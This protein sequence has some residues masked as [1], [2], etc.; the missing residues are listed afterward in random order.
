MRI[1]RGPSVN[2]GVHAAR[3]RAH[4]LEASGDEVVRILE[5]VDV[6]PGTVLQLHV[7][8]LVLAD[9]SLVL[10][11]RSRVAVR[12]ARTRRHAS[13]RALVSAAQANTPAD[14]A[15]GA[16]DPRALGRGADETDMGVAWQA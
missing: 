12:A 5:C 10:L 9:I 14:A 6:L 11:R 13:R 4:P 3:P 8:L 7:P 15:T 16:F 1:N 2:V